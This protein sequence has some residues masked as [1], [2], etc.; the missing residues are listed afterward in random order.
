MVSLVWGGVTI[1][2]IFI[3][4]ED[5]P[6]VISELLCYYLNFDTKYICTSLPFNAGNES[7]NPSN[8]DLGVNGSEEVEKEV[9][10]KFLKNA[11]DISQSEDE[12]G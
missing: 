7:S 2:F 4:A 8:V 12:E 1:F 9:E 3:L 5:D 11:K 6:N 10:V